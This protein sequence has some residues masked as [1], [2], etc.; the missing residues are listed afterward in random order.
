MDVPPV[1]PLGDELLAGLDA[2]LDQLEALAAKVLVLSS[3]SPNFFVAGADIELMA[4]LDGEGM[5]RY[6]DKTRR[7]LDRLATCGRV[8]IAAID[9]YA[10]GGGVELALAC[11]LRFATATAKLGL[12]E[13][14]LGLIPGAGGTQRLPRLVGRGRA[15]ELT[16]SGRS[17][18]GAE[19]HGM[20]LVDRVVAR[21]VVGFALNYASELATWPRTALEALLLCADAADGA[22]QQGFDVELE[23]IVRMVTEGEGR[24]G[25]RA[26][27]EKRDPT[28]AP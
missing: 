26:F 15:L 2:A 19:A 7:P 21:D 27:L 24:E 11:S 5:R 10:L 1:N 12:P 4:K 18:S 23:Q 6:I 8:T 13:V 14:K 22:T 20:G 28:F 25:L 16:L 17:V 9:G 3:A